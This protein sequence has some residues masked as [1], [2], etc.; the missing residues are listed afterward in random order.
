MSLVNVNKSADSCHMVT[1]TKVKCYP[2]LTA[3]ISNAEEDETIK[4]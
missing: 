4:F 2:L 1:L 3:F